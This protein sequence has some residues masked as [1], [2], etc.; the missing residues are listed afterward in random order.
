MEHPTFIEAVKHSKRPLVLAVGGGNDSVSTLFL[1][2][3]LVRD[4]GYSPESMTIVAMLPD[5]L[6]YQHLLPT[7]HRLIGEITHETT[8]SVQGRSIVPFPEKTLAANKN[9]VPN[10][11]I[12]KI[13]GISMREGSTGVANALQHLIDTDAYDLV[14]AIDVGGD[15]IAVEDNTGVLSPMM[16]GYMLH[17]LR[18]FNY[19]N[20]GKVPVVYSVFGLGTDGES[21]PTL[22][23]SALNRIPD[24]IEGTF[25]A[26]CLKDIFSFYRKNIEPNRHSRTADFTIKEIDGSGHDNPALFRGRFHVQVSKQEKPTVHYGDYQHEQDP[27]FY[28]KYYLFS[29]LS[30]VSNP[31]AFACSSGISWFARVQNDKTRVNH[32]LNGQAYMDVGSVLKKP[33]LDGVSLFFGTPSHRFDDNAQK[34]IAT[35]VAQSVLNGV[36]DMAIVYGDMCDLM[37]GLVTQ[38]FAVG[39]LLVGRDKN[40][41]LDLLR[42]LGM[43]NPVVC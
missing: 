17:A 4:Y 1:Q 30:Q 13:Y 34:A 6:D 40:I 37:G 41:M 15:F 7:T 43:I 39:L 25:D 36:Y 16:D 21:T 31:Y 32:E 35:E 11:P 3:Q 19:N 24:R 10:L 8:R 33:S 14:L 29:D 12:P 5:C 42:S 28:G 18:M 27:Y 23:R 38:P 26:Q 22:L 9:N 20:S 2:T